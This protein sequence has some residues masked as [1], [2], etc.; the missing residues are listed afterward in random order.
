MTI[1]GLLAALAFPAFKKFI[2][3]SKMSRFVSDCKVYT[4]AANQYLMATGS[5]EI[6]DT[7]TGEIPDDMRDY[8]IQ[9]KWETVTPIGGNWDFDLDYGFL[10]VG[11]VGVTLSNEN[12]LEMDE[13]FDDGDLNSGN[14]RL[15]ARNR[16]Y[17][18]IEE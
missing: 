12:L 1:I 18:V 6:E 3:T 9:S 2:E 15:V 17:W 13:R 10:G 11:A 14:M 8:I 4:G 16:V 5:M 7:D